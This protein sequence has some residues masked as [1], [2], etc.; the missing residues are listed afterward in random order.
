VISGFRREVGENCALLGY[1]TAGSCNFL[2]TFRDYRREVDE[3]CALLGYYTAG[4]GN[5]LPTFRDYIN[6]V[7][8][9]QDVKDGTDRLSR[10]KLPLFSA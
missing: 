9:G 4:S 10:K 7:F 2:P 8:N 6:L 3:N 1:Y 5:F